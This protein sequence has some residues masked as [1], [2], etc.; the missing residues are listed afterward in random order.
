[1][2][3]FPIATKTIFFAGVLA[4]FLCVPLTSQKTL[5][6]KD[7][8]QADNGAPG[9]DFRIRTKDGKTQYKPGEL[10]TI[11][12]LFTS[13]IAN[14]YKLDARNYDRSGHLE[15]D[16]Y[17]VDPSV[18][19]SEPLKDYLQTGMFGGSMGGL[20]PLPPLLEDKPYVI[21]QDLNEFV[22]FDRPGKYRLYVTNKRVGKFDPQQP[23]RANTLFRSTS[24]TIELEILTAD[25]DWQIQKLRETLAVVDSDKSI[26][27][28]ASCRV[29]RFLN[30][31]DA[32]AAMIRRYRGS[33]DG[34]DGEFHFGLLGSPRRQSIITQM[35]SR[36]VS[37]DHPVT[38]SFVRT[39]ATLV[40]LE[41][42]TAP[43]LPY[44]EVQGN[45][46]KTRQWQ[47]EMQ[48]RRGVFEEIDMQIAE[49]LSAAIFRKLQSA[50]AVSIDTLLQLEG[51][52]PK[53]KRTTATRAR[54]NQMSAELTAVFLDLPSSSQSRLLTFSWKSIASPA[55]LA[56]LRQLI[57]KP[58]SSAR[59]G[60]Y[61]DLLGVALLR[62]YELAP[63]EGR[64]AILKEMRRTPLRVRPS[65]LTILPVEGLAEFDSLLA[66]KLAS[67]KADEQYQVVS[68]NALLIARYATSGSL[69]SIRKIVDD[70]IGKADCMSQ[71]PF[72]AYFLRVDPAL[73]AEMLDNA[74]SSRAETRCFESELL[75]LADLYMSK[76]ILRAA[77]NHLNDPDLAVSIQAA[78]VVSK[79]GTEDEEQLLWSR[80]Q[81]WHDEWL[82]RDPAELQLTRKAD[83]GFPIRPSQIG[84]ELVR[85]IAGGRGW[86]MDDVKFERLKQLT[87]TPHTLQEISSMM[88]RSEERE[89]GTSVNYND[90]SRYFRVAQYEFH[91]LADFKEKLTQFPKGTSFTARSDFD[92]P[93]D[94]KVFAELSQ[95]LE[96]HGMKLVRSEAKN[97]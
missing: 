40:Y 82:G 7:V 90:G 6:Q 56:V 25:R 36:L 41:R 44:S 27:R 91:S 24:N 97:N 16:E 21:V 52:I 80:L 1:M 96:Q 63:D 84:E 60:T 67:L 31:E 15:A 23:D 33:T 81:R 30:T 49:Q 70:R 9:V 94:E 12:M 64:R 85:A 92:D 19:T 26:D 53:E 57:E 10:I 79:H 83:T 50:R 75:A 54:A 48:N 51:I 8:S 13:S 34:C 3:S 22:R 11:E 89:I 45:E 35:Q 2:K 76:E 73:G 17:H 5:A 4:A 47:T 59:D 66:E 28:R 38:G 29:L 77:I 69:S 32:E 42:F 87:L 55:M 58:P 18:G 62:F 72:L 61:N 95:F 39:L 74:L 20:M 46:E 43:M 71:T 37:P 14:T 78:A 68:E 86:L 65:E 93:S 88:R